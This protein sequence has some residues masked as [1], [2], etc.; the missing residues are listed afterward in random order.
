MCVC[1]DASVCT[2]LGNWPKREWGRGIVGGSVIA[3]LLLFA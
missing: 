3:V 2:E 1:M